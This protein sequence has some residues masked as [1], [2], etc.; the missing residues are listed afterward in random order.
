MLKAGEDKKSLWGIFYP[1]VPNMAALLGPM[2]GLGHN[3][4]IFMIGKINSKVKISNTVL[5]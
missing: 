3:S 2:T 4:I 5:F 1:N